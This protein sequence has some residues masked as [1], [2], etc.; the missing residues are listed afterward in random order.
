MDQKTFKPRA[1]EVSTPD[2]QNKRVGDGIQT[3]DIQS[4]NLNPDSSNPSAIKD[5]RREALAVGAHWAHDTRHT[6][7]ILAGVV[8]NWN[9]LPDALRVGILTMIRASKKGRP[10][11]SEVRSQTFLTQLWIKS[12]PA[13]HTHGSGASL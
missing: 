9:N 2:K 4:R 13:V 7:P 5:L 12:A 6:G 8:A 3:R 1:T 11:E 10:L